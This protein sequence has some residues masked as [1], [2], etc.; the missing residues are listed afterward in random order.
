MLAFSSN[1]IDT[2]NKYIQ[3]EYSGYTLLWCIFSGEL[4]DF[5][6]PF[7]TVIIAKDV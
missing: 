4:F 3:F 6:Y 5:Y 2:G 7:A 1:G